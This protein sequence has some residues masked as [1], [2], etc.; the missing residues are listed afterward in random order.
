MN[1]KVFS[2]HARDSY[3][4]DYTD[5]DVLVTLYRHGFRIA[6][7]RVVMRA[8]PSGGSIHAGLKPMYYLF[9][10]SLTIPLNLMR[11]EGPA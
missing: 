9:K 6:E 2:F 10:M 4:V 8:N 1:A 11:R 7:R 3:P 5:T